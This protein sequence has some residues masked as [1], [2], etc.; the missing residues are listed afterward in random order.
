MV[1]LV[2]GREPDDVAVRRLPQAID[3]VQTCAVLG[4]FVEKGVA[5]HAIGEEESGG[6]IEHRNLDVLPACT[7]L[8]RKERRGH[9]L[10]DGEGCRLVDDDVSHQVGNRDVGVVLD[11][12]VSGDALD[13]R[14]VD[15]A[16]RI[17]TRRPV[18]ADRNVDEIGIQFAQGGL[19]D[20]HAVDR[21]GAVVLH[22]DVGLLHESLQHFDPPLLRE[23]D[24][25]R[26]LAPVAVGVQRRDAVL[27]L[28]ADA[29]DVTV[30][31]CLD[32]DD[33]GALLGQD[34][35]C[36]GPRDDRGNVDDANTG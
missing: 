19:A 18:A 7:A 32:L 15:T 5:D 20:S 22:E 11:C 21:S 30:G 4:V 1:L 26:A 6:R 13:D 10:G 14:V 36:K 9:R 12:A 2:D 35:R 24:H 23:I 16:V 8:A 17:G 28:C 31:R 34:H 33:L 25:H 27:A 29:T 3:L